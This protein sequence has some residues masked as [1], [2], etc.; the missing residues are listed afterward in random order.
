MTARTVKDK[1]H[2]SDSSYSR[3]TSYAH[4]SRNN[5]LQTTDP[6]G[7]STTYTYDGRSAVLTKSIAAGTSSYEEETYV[8]DN[9]GRLDQQKDDN[10]KATK[11]EYDELNRVI[12]MHHDWVN[13]TGG[14]D[15][16]KYAYDKNDNVVMIL[17]PRGN[18]SFSDPD[19]TYFIQNTFD[20]ANRLTVRDP[21]SHFSSSGNGK[22]TYGYD[23]LGR[24]ASAVARNNG[25]TADVAATSFDY[26]FLG[27]KVEENT[28]LFGGATREY[29]F[30]YDDDGSRTQ[31]TY[32]N[33]NTVSFTRTANHMIDT[34]SSSI[35]PLGDLVDID[36]I[37]PRRVKT[38]TYLS[39]ASQQ[40]GYNGFREINDI[41][42]QWYGGGEL[43]LSYV[44][45]KNGNP[46]SEHNETD[47]TWKLYSYN[48]DNRLAQAKLNCTNDQGAGANPTLTWAFSDDIGNLTT[49]TRAPSSG[50]PIVTYACND[51]TNARTY[52]S[53]TSSSCPPST[54]TH[55]YD[56]AGN[57][58]SE[59][60]KS[61][62]YDYANRLIAFSGSSTWYYTY[63][64][65]GRRIQKRKSDDTVIIRSYYDGHDILEQ[66][67]VASST[68]RLARRFGYADG[69]DRPLFMMWDSSTPP[70]GAIDKMC[71]Y[72]HWDQLGSPIRITDEGGNLEEQYVFYE[73]YGT[74]EIKDGSGGSLSASAIGNPFTFTGREFDVESGLYAYRARAYHPTLGTFMQ[75]DPLGYAD[76]MNLQ[77][78][79]KSR[80]TVMA[81]PFGEATDCDYVKG[82][83]TADSA[84][85]QQCATEVDDEVNY[86]CK[87]DR[88]VLQITFGVTG[89][90]AGGFV[91]GLAH[92]GAGPLGTGWGLARGI[93][94][95]GLVG[96]G[97]G[98][99]ICNM[100]ESSVRSSENMDKLRGECYCRK[101][102]CDD[103]CCVKPLTEPP[104]PQIPFPALP[105]GPDYY[106]RVRQ[107]YDTN[108]SPYALMASTG[109][110]AS[111]TPTTCIGGSCGHVPMGTVSARWD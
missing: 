22:D 51:G 6:R 72:F 29:T 13:G 87:R 5:L 70:N 7:Y 24:L 59:P 75:R 35:V 79:V 19:P 26:D 18:L 102:K 68:E 4:D 101:K 81:D 89:A 37:G 10:N 48:R 54:P 49:L 38:T 27:R 11:Y 71:S 105:L 100:V 73:P 16:T 32:P 110:P 108:R 58:L 90:A 80:P 84:T 77:E 97:A 65:L 8:Y 28:T 94:K 82:C 36:Y 96:W 46:T 45:D 98:R 66:Y 78:Y 31:I 34:I 14:V 25:D 107:W 86:S 67:E 111:G 21:S 42:H 53:T 61:Y 64:A 83:P 60:S 2:P 1:D 17:D 41:L 56:L 50:S 69:I 109:A 15:T 12:A 47:S 85:L 88:W 20:A 3:V 9:A 99:M 76:S 74:V 63:D 44:R 57:M 23:A 93:F 33:T 104:F 95:G 30:T 106:E 43:H 40:F 62:T 39:G 103:K 91:Y 52:W 55:T 92:S